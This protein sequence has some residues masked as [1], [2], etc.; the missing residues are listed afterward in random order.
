MRILLITNT[1]PPTYTGGAEVSN[2]NV[3]RELM[4]RGHECSILFVNNRLQQASNEWYEYDGIPVH[5]VNFLTPRRR[6]ITDVFD[7]RIFSAVRREIR[8]L[9]PRCGSHDQHVR[10]HPG[11]VCSL[12]RRGCP[13]REYAA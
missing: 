11:S 4:R 7:R 10:R 3:C 8:R 6:P 12:P 5:R 13:G 2:Y 1:F 9:T